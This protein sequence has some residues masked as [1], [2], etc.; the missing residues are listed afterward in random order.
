MLDRIRGVAA[1]NGFPLAML[2]AVLLALLWPAP[3]AQGGW[4]HLDAITDLGVALVFF[5]HGANLSPAN[6]RSGAGNWRLH[7]TVQASTF[8]LFP[9]VGLVAVKS[10]VL[11]AEPALATGFLYLCALP[12]TITSSVAMTAVARG[13]VAGAIFN[14]TISGLVGMVATP[15]LLAALV[16]AQDATIP[17][18]P[19][20]AGIVEQLL[21][22]FALGQL[23]RP[24]IAGFLGRHKPLITRVDRGV[25][26]LI[27]Y[28]AFCE[29]TRSGLW[30]TTSAA[31]LSHAVLI[32]AVLLA[33][34]GLATRT[35]ARLL[36]M[37]VGDEIAAVF[38]GSKKSLASGMPMAK[39]LF[40]GHP[41]FGL[42]V[43]PLMLYHQL[44]LLLFSVV[45]TRYARRSDPVTSGPR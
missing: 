10:G 29:S 23:L 39:V 40:A 5:L 28:A 6:V 26:V 18:V 13:N 31:T 44:Q 34:V 32:C 43:L 22:P 19:A 9:L 20:I 14:A 33:G 21:L 15:L 35:L 12:S 27:V 24:R 1:A 8:L 38:C 7:A 25:I 2:A 11:P 16:S 4:L 37:P 30:A 3:G 36:G 17:V 45:A 41:G 42:I